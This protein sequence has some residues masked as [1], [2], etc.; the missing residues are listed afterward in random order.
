[1][2]INSSIF[3]LNRSVL[4]N[5]ILLILELNSTEEESPSVTIIPEKSTLRPLLFESAQFKD[6]FA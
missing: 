5:T 3:S 1:L 6:S 4:E 2:K